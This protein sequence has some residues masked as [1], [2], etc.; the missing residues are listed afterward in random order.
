MNVHRIRTAVV[1]QFRS[2]SLGTGALH[3]FNL[4]LTGRGS[5]VVVIDKQQFLAI[6]TN[7]DLANYLDIPLAQL[8]FFAYSNVV[9]YTSFSIP[10]SNGSQNRTISAPAPKLK[11]IQ[12]TLADTLS[13]IYD[14]P[15]AVHGF[16]EGRSIASNAKQHV[17]KRTI[18]KIDLADFF[19]SISSS[20]IRGLFKNKPFHFNDEVANT[21]T[22]LVC[23][24][25]ELPQGAP[26]SPVISNMICRRMDCAL[27]QF[28]RQ[29]RLKYTRYADD[30]A[31]SS[32]SKRAIYAVVSF[33]N[34]DDIRINQ[35][36]RRII[37]SNGFTINDSKTGVFSKGTR[38]VV[39]GIVVNEK[40]NFRREDYR[41]LRTLFHNW[42]CYGAETAAKKYVASEKGKRHRAVFF[43]DDND[44]FEAKFIAH[45]HGLLSYYLMIARENERHSRPLQRLWTSFYDVSKA[46][47][48]EMLPERMVFQLDSLAQFRQ[49]GSSVY[50]DYGERG[51]CFLVDKGFLI[52]ARHCI[53]SQ[54]YEQINAHYTDGSILNVLDG[55]NVNIEMSYDRIIED[56]P[57]YDWVVL[58]THNDLA[59]LPGL[60]SD[61]FY[62][63]QE[64]ESVFVYGYADGKRQLRKVEA[65]VA[66]IS[67]D[68]VHVDRA[69]I[70]GMS[71]GPVLNTRGDVIGLVTKGS[72]DG[73]YDRD[74]CFLP[75]KFIKPLT[76]A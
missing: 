42:G 71:G 67:Q 73:Y 55:N 72:G 2:Y 31:F 12:R 15:D 26:T 76:R 44:F 69:F 52:S 17:K 22:N 57:V 23:H 21:L 39:T 46:P 13:A 29:N 28:A 47:V 3:L 50:E 66:D 49:I 74:G 38:Q 63:V 5:V 65:K 20:R 30:L 59:R 25:G 48:P 45:I 9:F 19:P 1:P 10:K 54:N 43:S 37:S 32:T 58:P 24:N 14:P 70:E 18:V 6:R 64:G 11:L 41:Y 34:V 60:S 51:T 61:P 56:S 8:T 36:L 62:Q 68:E 7:R 35:N 16:L 53:K 4:F 33:D 40:C 27:M 75:L